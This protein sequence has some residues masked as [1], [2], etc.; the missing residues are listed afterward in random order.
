M[1]TLSAD[2]IFGCPSIADRPRHSQY[3]RLITAKAA[4]TQDVR[5]FLTSGGLDFWIENWYTGCFCPGKRLSM[6]FL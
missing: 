6:P 4:I 1:S 3:I 5:Y 2:M